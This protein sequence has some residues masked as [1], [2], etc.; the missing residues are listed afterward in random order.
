MSWRRE[1]KKKIWKISKHLKFY[2]SNQLVKFLLAWK[3]EL[4]RQ[5]EEEILKKNSKCKNRVNLVTFADTLAEFDKFCRYT[6]GELGELSRRQEKRWNF[7]WICLSMDMSEKLWEFFRCMLDELS[8]FHRCISG[9]KGRV[10]LMCVGG[11]N[12]VFSMPRKE[13]RIS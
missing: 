13:G 1:R 12:W 8:E 5:E 6:S 3:T 9:E 10:S 11:K 2:T 7:F 4:I